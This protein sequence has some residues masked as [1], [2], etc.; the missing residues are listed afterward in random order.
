M[1]SKKLTPTII[2]GVEFYSL[3]QVSKLFG[4]PQKKIQDDVDNGILKGGI[5]E[6]KYWLPADEVEKFL[7]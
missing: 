7:L 3:S 2:A 4:L 1:I 6:G 5:I